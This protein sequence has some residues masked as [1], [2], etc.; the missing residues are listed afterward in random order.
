[1]YKLII[2]FEESGG[3]VEW[4]QFLKL[5]EQMPGLR[6]ETITRP[7]RL[8]SGKPETMPAMIHELIFDSR[9]SLESALSS[10]EG[11]TAGQFLQSYAGGQVTILTSE[12]MEAVEQE[13]RKKE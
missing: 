3:G 11:R 2:I 4:Q 10:P 12:H 9:E 8:I 13:F 1:M 7:D 6:R 5:A